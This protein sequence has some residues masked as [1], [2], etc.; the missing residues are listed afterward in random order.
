MLSSLSRGSDANDLTRTTLK[1]QKVANAD[2]VARDGDGVGWGTRVASGGSKGAWGRHG[3]GFAFF[4]YN[5]FFTVLTVVVRSSVDR[6]KDTIG[7]AVK[8]VTERV[9]VAV[10]VVI[11]HVKLVLAWGIY[12]STGLSLNPNFL[13]DWSWSV[14]R[15]RIISS[16]R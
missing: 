5:V 1:N 4:D 3:D 7:S 2:V 13:L 15:I 6:M 9:V 10:L 8:S 14:G 11:S 12:G 16:S